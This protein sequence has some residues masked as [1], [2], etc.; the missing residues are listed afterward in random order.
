VNLTYPYRSTSTLPR[1]TFIVSASIAPVGTG[2]RLRATD[3]ITVTAPD[4]VAA[5]TVARV[6]LSRD[7]NITSFRFD[8]VREV[9]TVYNPATGRYDAPMVVVPDTFRHTLTVTHR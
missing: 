2:G 6:A 5:E 8:L 3:P 1:R 7:G 9:T 4:A